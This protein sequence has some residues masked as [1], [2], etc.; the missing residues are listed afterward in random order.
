MGICRRSTTSYSEPGAQREKPGTPAQTWRY[1]RGLPG[2]QAKD[3]QQG[4]TH[5]RH[6]ANSARHAG[7]EREH[8][9]GED[10]GQNKGGRDNF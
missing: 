4:Q 9:H 10:Q 7:Q 1:S 6:N 2:Q 8:R 5:T 3:R